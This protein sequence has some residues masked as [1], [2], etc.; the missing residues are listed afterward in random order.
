MP[1]QRA[2]DAATWQAVQS[3]DR[4]G[5]CTSG[6]SSS[7]TRPSESHIKRGCIHLRSEWEL[8]FF[9]VVKSSQLDLKYKYMSSR[10]PYCGS[11]ADLRTSL[12]FETATAYGSTTVHSCRQLAAATMYFRLRRFGAYIPNLRRFAVIPGE[13]V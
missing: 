8:S 11:W 10:T 9:E 6:A 13:C 4:I 3:R 12:R 2:T 7:G 5:D 1:E